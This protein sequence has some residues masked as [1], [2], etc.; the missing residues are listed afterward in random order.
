MVG[1][2]GLWHACHHG[3]TVRRVGRTAGAAGHV[4]TSDAA[5]IFTAPDTS[6]IAF[7]VFLHTGTLPTFAA[8]FMRQFRRSLV[9]NGLFEFRIKGLRIS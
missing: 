5:A 2:D 9:G 3:N 6:R 1:G 7:T 4:L 8:Q